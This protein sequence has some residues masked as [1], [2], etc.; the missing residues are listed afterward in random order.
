MRYDLAQLK[1]STKIKLVFMSI[2]IAIPLILV[3]IL[4]AISRKYFENQISISVNV[5]KYTL[6]IIAEG[7]IITRVVMYGVLLGNK[8]YA[9]KILIKKNDEREIFI[10]QKSSV[11]AIKMMFFLLVMAI[12][13]TGFIN[14]IAFVTLCCVLV[15]L[16]ITTLIT[17][18]YYKKKY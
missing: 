7:L 6:L 2:T 5:L 8:S 3:F 18:I 9:E 17:S 11:F 4:E 1:K 13:I 14:T 10:R 12:F 15:V 16:F